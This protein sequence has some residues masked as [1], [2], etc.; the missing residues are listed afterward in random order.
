MAELTNEK[1]F[2]NFIEKLENSQ[3]LDPEFSKF[4]DEHFWELLDVKE[5]K[6][7]SCTET[8][9]KSRV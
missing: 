3:D 6:N 1:I 8:S 4:V 7:E 9:Q 5:N 2:K